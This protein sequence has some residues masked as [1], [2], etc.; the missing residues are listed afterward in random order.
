MNKLDTKLLLSAS[1]AFV[2]YT[3]ELVAKGPNV[4]TVAITVLRNNSTRWG[5]LHCAIP[6]SSVDSWIV[7]YPNHR[8]PK[9][10]KDAIYPIHQHRTL[11]NI[12]VLQFNSARVPFTQNSRSPSNYSNYFL[13]K[14]LPGNLTNERRAGGWINN[15]INTCICHPQLLPYV[16]RNISTEGPK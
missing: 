1:T 3:K 7:A 15:I 16:T 4:T 14:S 13:G 11:K 5:S 8:C 2:R 12:Q 6:S 10:K 9:T